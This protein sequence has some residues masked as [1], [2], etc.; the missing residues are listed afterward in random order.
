[1]RELVKQ[2]LI[3]YLHAKL[4]KHNAVIRSEDG[5]VFSKQPVWACTDVSNAIGEFKSR[6]PAVIEFKV[7]ADGQLAP[8]IDALHMNGYSVQTS[9]VWKEYPENGINYFVVR[10]EENSRN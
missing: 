4:Q 7:P 1:M 2:E 10:A 8:L 3:D 9:V 6:Y 5:R